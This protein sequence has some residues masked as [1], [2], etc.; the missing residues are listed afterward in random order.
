MISLAQVWADYGVAITTMVGGV[1]GWY[2]KMAG[3]RIAD[4]RAQLAAGR[5]ALALV[6][7]A[8]AREAKLEPLLSDLTGRVAELMR[9]R[10]QSDDALQD[11][12]AQAISARLT[13]QELDAQAGRP[14]RE[15]PPLPPYPYPPANRLAESDTLTVARGVVETT[16]DPRDAGARISKGESQYG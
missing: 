1:G 3:I 13:I 12:Y 7:R 9:Q 16:S 14:P 5:Q 15:F 11:L 10:W 6:D 4:D 8:S 2:A